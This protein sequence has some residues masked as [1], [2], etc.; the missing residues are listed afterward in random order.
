[1]ACGTVGQTGHHRC[2]DDWKRSMLRQTPDTLHFGRSRKPLDSLYVCSVDHDHASMTVGVTCQ[3]ASWHNAERFLLIIVQSRMVFHFQF[4]QRL[5]SRHLSPFAAVCHN[6]AWTVGVLMQ[7][8]SCP[9]CSFTDS[10]DDECTQSSS[11][12]VSEALRFK[13]SPPIIAW[14][15]PCVRSDRGMRRL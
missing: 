8:C 10:E 14:K 9:T 1:M 12:T 6:N 2:D 15:K 3:H 7:K 11:C 13:N 4:A 5:F